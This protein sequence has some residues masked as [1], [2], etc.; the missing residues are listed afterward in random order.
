[1]RQ[2]LDLLH[3]VLL[4][5]EVKGDRTG[6]GI[7]SLFGAQLR[8]N[9]QEGFPLVTTKRIHTKS[10]IHELLWFLMGDTNIK[11][12]KDNG[13]TI[14]NEWA[15]E[16]GDL[17][18][19]YGK[20]WRHW[21]GYNF[22]TFAVHVKDQ[23]AEVI[24]E[25]K[26]TPDSRRMIVS[27]WNPTDIYQMKLPPCHVLYQFNVANGRLSC[28]MYIRSCDLFLGLPFNIASY[29]LLTHMVAQVTD[30]EPGD[31]IISFGDAHIYSNHINQVRTQ[32]SREPC[33]L[34][35]LILNPE[36][37]DIDAFTYEDVRIEGYHSYPNIPA[38]IAV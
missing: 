35:T 14:W 10:V 5:D 2:Y 38:P 19:V 16:N 26:E 36:V 33:P 17:G 12:L 22:E 7:L 11:Y 29:A 4:T 8:F 18:P 20:Q 27:A 13:V 1:M 9:L 6:T 15:D 24:Q 31:L 37:K 3:K 28:S 25:I 23:L 21:V 34:P 30:L 32:L